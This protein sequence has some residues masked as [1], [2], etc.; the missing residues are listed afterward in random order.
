MTRSQRQ[1]LGIKKW[2]ESNCR[3]TLQWCTGSGS[4]KWVTDH[5]F[6]PIKES[7]VLIEESSELLLTNIGESCNA[8][9][10]INL[11]IS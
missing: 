9:P 2:I 3:G 8:N 1:E 7:A 6:I 5:S 4:L 10:E 11:E